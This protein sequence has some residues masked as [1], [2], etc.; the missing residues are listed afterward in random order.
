MTALNISFHFI[1]GPSLASDS[2]QA[3]EAAELLQLCFPNFE[4]LAVENTLLEGIGFHDLDST[5]WI[6]ARDDASEDSR[7]VGM[8]VAVVY[9][10]GLYLQNFCVA[11]KNRG[12]GLG[13]DLLE[14]AGQLA[15]KVGRNLLIGNASTEDRH[16]I[17]YYSSLGAKIIRTG[18]GGQSSDNKLS[19]VRFV[20]EIPCA[21]VAVVD[22][23]ENLREKRRRVR[24]GRRV[25]R[26]AFGMIAMVAISAAA[27]LI[28]RKRDPI[29][30]AQH[31]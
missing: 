22:F 28:G 19:S 17:D 6:I 20:R 26:L 12:R 21:P 30:E 14:V 9:H 3:Q 25:G 16:I 4:G 8:I 24:R 18:Q 23:F 10:N 31:G 5:T 13:L 29:R 1:P 15:V 11:P 7:I 27:A 2:C